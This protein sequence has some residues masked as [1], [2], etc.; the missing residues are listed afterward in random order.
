MA[1]DYAVLDLPAAP[2]DRQ[3]WMAIRRL[4]R[5]AHLSFRG[6]GPEALRAGEIL[7]VPLPA[8][9]CRAARNGD[10]AALW[11]GPDEWLLVG[12]SDWEAEAALVAGLGEAA[13]SLV[14]VSHRHVSFGLVGPRA[15][16]VLNAGCPLDLDAAAFPA[17]M[18][19]RTILGKV[20]IILWRIG[21]EEF[22]LIAWRSF[23][24]YVLD[25]LTEARTR[26]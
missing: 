19:T 18:C 17:G 20:Q 6:A 26:L 2:L 15:A 21:A 7:G 10:R 23:A 8:A 11:L 13:Y 25:F 14:G 9:A 5:A 22:T 24:P 16:E 1:D 4:P 12:P 3:A